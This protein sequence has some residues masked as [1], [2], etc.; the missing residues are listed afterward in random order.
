M[1]ASPGDL[2]SPAIL[3][4]VAAAD[5]HRYDTDIHDILAQ[6]VTVCDAV[7]TKYVQLQTG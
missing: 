6:Q 2:H 7:E 5:E 4:G 3:L 1:R